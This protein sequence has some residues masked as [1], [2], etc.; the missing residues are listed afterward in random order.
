MQRGKPLEAD[1]YFLRYEKALDS[2]YNV[3]NIEIIQEKE[4]EFR[5]KE[6]EQQLE[7]QEAELASQRLLI[8]L[9]AVGVLLLGLIGFLVYRQQRL[10]IKHQRQEQEL[11]EALQAVETQNKLEEQRLRIS[12][13]L[14]DNIGSQLTYLASASQNIGMGLQKTSTEVTQQK[15]EDLSNFSQD[16][17]RDLRDTIWVMNRNS[18]TWDDLAERIRYLAQKVSNTTGIN[19]SVTREGEDGFTL[20]PSATMNVFRIIQEAINNAVK[21]ASASTIAV[22][23]LSGSPAVVTIN[24]DGKGYNISEV[25]SSSNGL[26]NMESRAKMLDATLKMSSSNT[27]TRFV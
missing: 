27:G 25:T 7:L 5:T 8:V 24:D 15:I 19:V 22:N 6:K 4:T 21:H 3:K 17:I 23:V 1:P 9:L 12:K 20:D 14:H 13:E 10:K 11:K 16:A 26:K 2:M 18:V